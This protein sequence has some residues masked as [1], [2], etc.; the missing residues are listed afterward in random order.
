MIIL[1]QCSGAPDRKYL[2][3]PTLAGRLFLYLVESIVVTLLE[4]KIWRAELLSTGL[5]QGGYVIGLLWS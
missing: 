2:D 4:S 5:F 3:V 1:Q